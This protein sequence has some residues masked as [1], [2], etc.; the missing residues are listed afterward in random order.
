MATT[1]YSDY[2]Y[3]ASNNYQHYPQQYQ[4]QYAASYGQPHYECKNLSINDAFNYNYPPNNYNDQW[5]SYYSTIQQPE[6]PQYHQQQQQLSMLNNQ[7][8]ENYSHHNYNNAK[9]TATQNPPNL[10]GN[11]YAKNEDLFYGQQQQNFMQSTNDA[12]AP[13]SSTSTTSHYSATSQLTV[14]SRKRKIDNAAEDSPALRA[15]LSKPSKRAKYVKSPY[16]YQHSHGGNVSPA[17]STSEHYQM[18]STVE[19]SINLPNYKSPLKEGYESS[20]IEDIKIN[21]ST[22]SP[23]SSS[24]ATPPSSPK[25]EVSLKHDDSTLSG[26]SAVWSEQNDGKFISTPPDST[27]FHITITKLLTFSIFCYRFAHKKLQ[28]NTTDIH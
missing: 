9:S 23:I 2:Y 14:E 11:Q 10:N 17:S 25:E 20:I 19:Q 21:V 4:Q 3:N 1:Q 16:F 18:P 28:A 22:A 27:H 6:Q 13:T 12:I 15:L 5:S 24:Y 7:I 26:T 8:N